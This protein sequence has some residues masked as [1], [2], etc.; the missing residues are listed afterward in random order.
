[1]QPLLSEQQSMTLWR[2]LRT[3]CLG[4]VALALLPVAAF[5]ALYALASALDEQTRTT[6][7]TVL[8]VGPGEGA[9]A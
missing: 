3:G 4:L 7:A 8:A 9:C 2:W 5:S 6:V 1:M